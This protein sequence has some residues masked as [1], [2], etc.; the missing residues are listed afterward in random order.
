MGTDD[1]TR[2]VILSAA[3]HRGTMTASDRQMGSF[4]TSSMT[5]A[6]IYPCQ[7]VSSVVK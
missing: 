1:Q 3:K 6:W 5:D 7:S 2:I 4:A